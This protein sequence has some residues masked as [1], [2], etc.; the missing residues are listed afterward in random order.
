MAMPYS[1][2]VTRE[3]VIQRYR[4]LLGDRPLIIAANRAPVSIKELVDPVTHTPYRKVVMGAGGLVT[5]LSE[6]AGSTHSLWIGAGAPGD[7][8][9]QAALEHTNGRV[10]SPDGRSYRIRL[11]QP[12]ARQYNDHYNV[13]SNPLLWFLQHYLWDASKA[14]S[15]TSELSKAWTDGYRAV[16]SLFANAIIE[17]AHGATKPPVILIQDYQLYCVAGEVRKAL[18]TATIQQFVHIPWTCT[19]Y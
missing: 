5:A 10:S 13:V 6:L 3:S 17:E 18:P 4:S 19:P 9:L 15:H 14:P 8:L 16:N 12:T 7:E 1:W 2:N 11:V